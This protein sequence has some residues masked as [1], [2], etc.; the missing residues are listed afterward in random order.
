[1]SLPDAEELL[2]DLAAQMRPQVTPDT[3]LV[4]LHTGGV[5]LAQR[6]H[7]LLGLN[8]PA[9]SLDVSFYRDDYAQRG[10]SRDTR[11]S[12]LPFDVEG[13]HLI[14]VD[15]V[16]HTGR[17]IRAALN[18]LFDYGRPAK[19][20]LAVLIDR[21]GRQLPVAPTY[22]ATRLDLPEGS[23]VKLAQDGE[24]LALRLLQEQE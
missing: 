15:D 17:T 7:A 13:R 18:E 21:G 19:V 22:C 8:Q 5:W 9:G 20:E 16:L 12:S 11:S 6:L 14:L 3:A 23:R 1:M 24:R 2:A 10:L 4:G